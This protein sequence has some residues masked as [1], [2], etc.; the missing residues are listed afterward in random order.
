MESMDLESDIGPP[1]RVI[2]EDEVEATAAQNAKE[3][4]VPGNSESDL[5]SG[6]R[7]HNLGEHSHVQKYPNSSPSGFDLRS[8]TCISGTT[9]SPGFSSF[10]TFK[11]KVAQNRKPRC[12]SP[13][14]K[15]IEAKTVSN[16]QKPVENKTVSDTQKSAP[17]SR[18]PKPK[19]YTNK[20][21]TQI[22]PPLIRRSAHLNLSSLTSIKKE[23]VTT[24]NRV[25][26]PKKVPPPVPPR[27]SSLCTISKTSLEDYADKLGNVESQIKLKSFNTKSQAKTE[28]PKCCSTEQ[29][30]QTEIPKY[31]LK[32][33]ANKSHVPTRSSSKDVNKIQ[34]SSKGE[35]C[36]KLSLRRGHTVEKSIRPHMLSSLPTNKPVNAEVQMTKH[37]SFESTEKNGQVV[38]TS[39]GTELEKVYKKI[40]KFNWNS[41][42]FSN[43]PS[44][45]SPSSSSTSS[46]GSNNIENAR[47]PDF[48]SPYSSLI[49]SSSTCS[50]EYDIR[51]AHGTITTSQIT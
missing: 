26:R 28:K 11:P 34:R 50:I 9:I 7:T 49:S 51:Q 21:P 48:T 2:L 4:V 17:A 8:L 10:E 18:L 43:S 36:N 46:C 19:I 47:V 42:E 44:P 31:S 16:T 37:A 3:Y 30:T 27:R 5:D 40:T 29:H 12:D 35:N 24:E 33:S 25:S 20:T 45:L 23:E 39:A 41:T 22:K 38:M 6:V 14:H 13:M 15:A 32:V 1:P